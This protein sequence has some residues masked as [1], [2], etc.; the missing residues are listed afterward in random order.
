MGIDVR[1]TVFIVG[2]C[3]L[4]CLVLTLLCHDLGISYRL[5]VVDC[6]VR[7]TARATECIIIESKV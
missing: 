7:K 4:H 2:L 6:A 3:Y 1:K 5:N